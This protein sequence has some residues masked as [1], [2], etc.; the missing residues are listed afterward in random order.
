MLAT[1]QEI[2]SF[3]KHPNA[4]RLNL[5]EIL[6]WQCVTA[7]A[8]EVDDLCCYIQIDTLLPRE[9][10]C[11]FLFNP[12]KPEQKQVRLKTIRL[13]KEISQGLILPLRII[14]ALAD[15]DNNIGDDVSELLKIEKYI[16]PVPADT[17]NQ[18]KGNFPTDVISKTDEERIQ[19]IP[20]ILDELSGKFV[21]ITMKL[22][23]TSGTY[24]KQADEDVRVCS[25]NLELKEPEAGDKGSVYWQMV[26]KYKLNDLPDEFVVQGEIAGN[27]LQKNPMKLPDVQLFVF[28]VYSI[29]YRKFLDAVEVSQFCNENK[30]QQ[31]PTVYNGKFEWTT[32]QEL[33]DFADEQKYP[34]TKSVAEGIVIRTNQETYSEVLRGRTSFKVISNKYALKHGE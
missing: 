26:D 25:R 28:N 22:D 14:P 23:G 5:V 19:N 31:V 13:R 24:I 30:L 32:I 6:G 10:W 2:K 20:R 8:Y 15:R 11:E 16:K 4:D 9:E 12:D 33:L 7:E 1:I 34:N 3:K 27:G 29:V 17:A 18:T 21:N